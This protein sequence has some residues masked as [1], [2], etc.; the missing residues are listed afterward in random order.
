M[1]L[2]KDMGYEIYPEELR[3]LL[4]SDIKPFEKI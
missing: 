4:L 2:A 1:D 3:K